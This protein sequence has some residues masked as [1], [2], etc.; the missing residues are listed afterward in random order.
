M[1]IF[2][3]NIII[4]TLILCLSLPAAGDCRYPLPTRLCNSGNIGGE[5]TFDNLYALTNIPIGVAVSAGSEADSVLQHQAQ[6]NTIRQHFS[7]IVAGNIMKMS[8][9]HP[10]EYTYAFAD[11]DAL[12]NWAVV[13][14]ISLH[15]HTLIWHSD[16]QVP[17]WMKN[18]TGD[19]VAM[20]NDHVQTIAAHYSGKVD[21]WDVVNEAFESTGYRNSIFFQN[22]GAEYLENAFVTARAADPN[23][24]LYYN[25]F[26]LVVEPAKLGHVLDM[27]DDFQ[28]R[29][30]PIDGI[31][32]QMHILF[33]FPDNTAIRNAFQQVVNRGLKVKISELDVPVNNPFAGGFPQ[34]TKLT[35]QAA[36]WQ[37]QRYHDIVRTYLNTVPPSQ[38]GGIVVWGLWDSQ[39]WLLSLPVYQGADDWPLLFSSPGPNGRFTPKP[40]LQG[41]GNALMRM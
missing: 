37:K 31:G 2:K 6:Q 21:S 4:S 27:V 38:R 3:R 22:I 14:G 18:Y 8:Y 20:L 32:F 12:C 17:D 16:Y 36:E 9:L 19:W 33:G 13:N 26:N 35:K 25:D 24:L 10:Q 23:A 5:V 41:F 15:G 28:N 11:A 7:Q 40:A 39:S 34:Y 29:G 1:F 30:I